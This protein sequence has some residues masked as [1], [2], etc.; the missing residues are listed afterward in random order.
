M[1]KGSEL[2][3]QQWQKRHFVVVRVVV[4]CVE[5]YRNEYTLLEHVGCRWLYKNYLPFDIIDIKVIISA[6]CHKYLR[7]IYICISFPKPLW[8][9]LM[10]FSLVQFHFHPA[11]G[12]I[13]QWSRSL[14]CV[15]QLRVIYFFPFRTQEVIVPLIQ[16]SRP[17]WSEFGS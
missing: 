10:P 15:D 12:S 16:Q 1:Q 5:K 9:T 13:L 8:F 11:G 2:E 17:A 6:I 4:G 14:S 7:Y 3:F